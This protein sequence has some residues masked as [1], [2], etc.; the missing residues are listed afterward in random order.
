MRAYIR[1]ELIVGETTILRKTIPLDEIEF[2][3]FRIKRNKR[4]EGKTT[5]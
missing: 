5:E 1:V 3:N 2:D 4:T